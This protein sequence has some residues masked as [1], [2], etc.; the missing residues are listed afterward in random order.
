MKTKVF[1]EQ[2]EPIECAETLEIRPINGETIGQTISAAG[3]VSAVP[4]STQGQ[5]YGYIEGGTTPAISTQRARTA[6][7]TDTFSCNVGSLAVARSRG[8]GASSATCGITF[9]GDPGPAS[10]IQVFPYASDTTTSTD[11]GNLV[12]GKSYA[13]QASQ[14]TTDAY[15]YG[16]Y[17]GTDES[18]DKFNFASGGN[19]S[20]VGSVY[21]ANTPLETGPNARYYAGASFSAPTG[22]YILGGLQPGVP[23]IGYFSV[24]KLSAALGAVSATNLGEILCHGRYVQGSFSTEDY[25]IH[26]GGIVSTLNP[27]GVLDTEGIDKFP[28]A[29]ETAC[30]TS[31]TA[32]YHPS[33]TANT[34]PAPIA[35]CTAGYSIGGAGT[36]ASAGD[37]YSFASESQATTITTTGRAALAMGKKVV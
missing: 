26:H 33:P 6:F 8:G 28:W 37:K 34:Y 9:G 14:T 18:I 4:L 32:S 25:G 5:T 29:S 31:Y 1:L 17:P 7:A 3:G 30:V 11:V 23:T 15:V 36:G 12:S 2:L 21:G 10:D 22:M 27:A 16:G 13:E 24:V 20:C 19:S 35:S